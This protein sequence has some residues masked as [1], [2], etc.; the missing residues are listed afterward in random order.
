MKDRDAAWKEHR[1]PGKNTRVRRTS[2][3]AGWDAAV[4]NADQTQ[5]RARKF[6]ETAETRKREAEERTTSEVQAVTEQLTQDME[7]RIRA[8]E[9][10]GDRRVRE[11]IE[12]MTPPKSTRC[13]ARYEGRSTMRCIRESGHDDAHRT[14]TGGFWL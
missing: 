13:E 1:G 8:I 10:D 6:L 5:R 9:A 3:D 4:A 14:Q 2:F 7:Q 12:Q 11:V